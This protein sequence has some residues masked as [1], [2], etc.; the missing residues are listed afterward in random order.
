MKQKQ[1][2]LSHAISIQSKN[3]KQSL[4]I[5]LL[6]IALL[7]VPLLA[8][9]SCKVEVHPRVNQTT[10]NSNTTHSMQKLNLTNANETEVAISNMSNKLSFEL[11]DEIKKY[12]QNSN[13]FLS[14]F[15]IYVALSMAYN[16]ARGKTEQQMQNLLGIPNTKGTL[17]AFDNLYRKLNKNNSKEDSYILSLANLIWVK[18]GFNIIPSYLNNIQKYFHGEVT[19][20]ADYV[21][22]W[23]EKQ[24]HGKISYNLA[25]DPLLRVVLVN[26]IYFNGSWVYPFEKSLTENR[27]FHITPTKS[28]KTKMMTFSDEYHLLNYYENSKFQVV[29]LPYKSTNS[30]K[31]SMIIFLPKN[32]NTLSKVDSELNSNEF[33]NIM[34]HLSKEKVNVY[35]PRFNLRTQYI[36]NSYLKDLGMGDAFNS[37]SANFS[38]ISNEQLY[39]SEV[40]H[41]TFLN[42]TE[43]GTV[44]AAITAI[45]MRATAAL[46]PKHEKIIE[47]DAN[48]PFMFFIV[49]ISRGNLILFIGSYINPQ[50]NPSF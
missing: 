40:I 46:P 42:V 12:N 3:N 24:T 43:K 39:I 10:T 41:K 32:N 13:T 16:G 25:P 14:P 2:R 20:N 26:A 37:H 29:E 19:H 48:H 6:V 18:Q 7:I 33:N 5:S 4:L 17:T 35:L 9:S 23:V 22:T 34:N 28:V 47:F 49:D 21:S 38:G 15:S 27:L 31:L 8:L 11:Y 30:D 1:I 36:L 50:S 44:A 45:E